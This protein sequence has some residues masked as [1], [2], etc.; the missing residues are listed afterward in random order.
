MIRL[1]VALKIPEK[2][3]QHLIDISR[4]L[5]DEQESFRWES[6]EK[7]HLTLKFIGEVEENLTSSFEDEL[8]F[9]EEYDSFEFNV[10][11]FGFFFRYNDPKILCAGLETDE[12]IHK[13]VEELN[14][15]FSKYSI[16][17]EKRKFKPHLTMLRLKQNP[18]S[19]FISKFKEYSIGNIKFNSDEIALVKSELSPTGARY[20]DIKIYNLK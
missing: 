18:G 1:F 3:K 16:P 20:T 19:N 2:I 17:I 5:A 4:K 15:K 9:V 13:L 8:G 7:I 10:T 6:P 14:Y 12:R 11:R